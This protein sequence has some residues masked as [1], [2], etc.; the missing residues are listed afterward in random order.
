MNFSEV[1]AYLESL[2]IMPKTM[3]G[4]D[5]MKMAF[6]EVSWFSDI[7]PSRVIIVAGTNGKG[8]T[9]AAL[10]SLLL[11]AG[12]K[13]GFYSSPHLISTTERIRLNGNDISE[14]DFV[15]SFLRC[16]PVIEKYGLTHFESLTL[17]MAEFFFGEKRLCDL[18]FLILE[19]G[20][21]GE[22]DATNAIPHRY[23]IV[24]KLGYDHTNI[25][26]RTIEDIARTK[27][28]VVGRKN[29]VVHHR[30]PAEV[31]QVQESIRKKTNSNWVEAEEL[32]MSVV[33][34]IQPQYFLSFG[35]L[36]F[37]TNVMGIRGAENLASAI[38]MFQILGFDLRS[39]F[40]ALR[41]IKWGGRMQIV[42]A[43]AMPCALYVSGDHN[44]QGIDSLIDI[45]KD[46]ERDTL[47]LVVGI[48]IDKEAD[49]MLTKLVDL[50][51][52]RVYL[53]KTPFKGR[54]L[55]DYPE[56]FIKKAEASHDDVMKLLQT[57]ALN[58]KPTD[59]C[60]VTG[61]LYLVGAVLKELKLS[62]S[63]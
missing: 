7:D 10:E 61:S 58:A 52:V 50:P 8:T 56:Y 38:T 12:Q 18:D 43:S 54:S 48:G 51:R 13:T 2:Q 11:Q 31:A 59:L 44:E 4:L 20:L 25:L 55:S 42:K 60:I 3:P 34:G 30:L 53:T 45:L 47:H 24:T 33:P 21:G 17:M 6:G 32:K 39:Y 36:K 62:E 19:V 5:K 35:D 28:G 22:F 16:K 27:F 1:V 63:I 40:V 23:C 29:I 46:F 57:V 37:K 14:K 26:G 49:A 15:A 41:E 9:C